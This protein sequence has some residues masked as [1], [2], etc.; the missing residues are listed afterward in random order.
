MKI[1]S[2]KQVLQRNIFRVWPTS[3][4]GEVSKVLQIPLTRQK[5]LPTLL[6]KVLNWYRFKS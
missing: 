6:R 2:D 3:L 1:P 4:H 5:C